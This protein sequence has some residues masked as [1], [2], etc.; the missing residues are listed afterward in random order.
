MKRPEQMEDYE[1]FYLQIPQSDYLTELE[2][3][4]HE[5]HDDLTPHPASGLSDE[6]VTQIARDAL[7]T[8]P[9]QPH[10]VVQDDQESDIN[11]VH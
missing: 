1:L 4:A 10:H 6:Q 2:P 3:E 5:D 7:E 8:G 11:D 9:G